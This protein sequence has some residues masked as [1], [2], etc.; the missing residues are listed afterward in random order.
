MTS[1]EANENAGQ[2][3]LAAQGIA[4]ERRT[5]VW[6]PL[7]IAGGSL[8][9]GAPVRA[10]AGVGLAGQER[11]DLF[12]PLSFEQLATRWTEL[13][14]ALRVAPAEADE[15]YAGQLA[16]LL[17]RVPREMLPRLEKGR[18]QNGFT[19]GPSWF[20]APCV[21]VEFRMEPGAELR[22]HNHPPQVVMTLGLEGEARYEHYEIEGAAPPCTR[23][24]GEE[25]RVRQTRA[26]ILRPGRTT[27]LT[28][29]RDGI[30]GFVAGKEGACLVDFTVATTDDIETFSYIELSDEPIDPERDVFGAVWTGK[31]S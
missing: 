5:L 15:S 13:G 9:Q 30:H 8:L 24:D 16:G 12:A 11:D 27:T 1:S 14:K 19:A 2:G 18:G 20:M 4:I 28:R 23:I 31:G 10:E 22:R 25:F 17:A 6:L 7:A 21:M 26:G 29:L 3:D